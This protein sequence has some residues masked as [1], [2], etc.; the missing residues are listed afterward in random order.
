M[1]K[2]ES[3][4]A[5]IFKENK[6]IVMYRNKQNREYYTFIGGGKNEGETNSECVAREVYE[7]L[8][9]NVEPQ[10]EIYFYENET[11]IQ[12]FI[13]CKWISGEF[14]TGSGEEF[15]LKNITENNFYKPMLIDIDNISKIN[16]MPE[17]ISKTLLSDIKNYGYGL[18]NE[19]KNLN[20]FS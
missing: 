14:G 12:H 13:L 5:I 17:L 7:E 15:D 4:R 3:C 19:I 20:D 1:K 2:R 18:S 11:T 16:L 10:R 9:I 6:I 8:G